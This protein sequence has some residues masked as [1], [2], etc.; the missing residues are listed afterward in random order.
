M[1]MYR[2]LKNV[3]NGNEII[4]R[5][6]IGRAPFSADTIAKLIEV[7]AIAPIATP[8]LSVLP[9]WETR[10]NRLEQRLNILTIEQFLEADDDEIARVMRK[11]A[12]VVSEWKQD[13]VEW[14][15][16]KRPAG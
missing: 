2:F 9:G 14:M 6:A 15:K 16:A 10:S 1:S 7:G 3:T 13:V 12:Q 5:G 11:S 4:E 8:P